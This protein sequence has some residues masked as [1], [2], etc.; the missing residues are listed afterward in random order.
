MRARAQLPRGAASASIGLK[1]RTDELLAQLRVEKAAADAARREAEVAN[2]AKTQFF[3]AASH[4]LRQPLHAMGL[5]AEALR[6][7]AHD[8]EV[9]QLVNSINESVDALEG[10]FSELLDITRID[11]G[12]VEV[13]PQHVRA[14]RPLPQAAAALRAGGVREGAG[15]ALPRRRSTSPSPTRCWSSASCATWSRNAIRYT[16]DGGVLVS[17]RRRGERLLLQVWDTGIG[18]ARRRA[19]RASSRSSTRCRATGGGRAAPAQGPRPR[20]GDRQAAG[21]TDGGAARRCARSPAAARCSR[22]SCRSAGG[23][24]VA[25]RP[26]AAQ[27][28]RSASRC[29][30]RLIVVVED[31]PAVREGLEVLLH[32]L[33]RDDRRRFDSVAAGARLGRAARRRAAPD[34]LIVDYRLG[35]GADRRRRARRAARALRPRRCRRSSS[36]AAR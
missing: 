13:N 11:T 2:R 36:P 28:R 8:D 16:D 17:C 33:G 1:L 4:D 21:A 31:E 3:A 12:G 22:S 15:A 9:A 30:G 19:G 23:A 34:L 7:S 32:G 29:E 26:I 25:P 18:I 27:G 24:G 6:A 5:F 14:R 20:P 35:D 10:L